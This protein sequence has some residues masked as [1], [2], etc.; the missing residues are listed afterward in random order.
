MIRS[1]LTSLASLVIAMALLSGCSGLSTRSAP[2]LD[3]PVPLTLADVAGL[4][5]V[6]IPSANRAEVKALAMGSARSKGWR[7]LQSGDDRLIVERPLDSGSPLA[8]ALGPEAANAPAGSHLEVTTYFID[9]PGALSVASRAELVMPPVLPANGDRKKAPAEAVRIDQTEVLRP[10]LDQSL[11]ALHTSWNAH[12]S[13]LARAAP[14]LPESAQGA[15]PEPRIAA[16]STPPA[17]GLMPVSAP[18]V[19]AAPAAPPAPVS[20]PAPSVNLPSL[21]M[22]SL[23]RPAPEL[24][25]AAPVLDAV[26][27]LDASPQPTNDM[28]SL[29]ATSPVIDNR[30]GAEAFAAQQGCRALPGGAVM[31]DQRTDGDIIK[32]SCDSG[33]NLLL[34]CQSGRCRSL[35]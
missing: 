4:P 31:V 22:P 9:Q 12:G 17:P 20:R 27:L 21:N 14:P 3:A 35:L 33:Q 25:T 1:P 5:I 15:A 29:P 18:A 6:S 8:R 11:S 28:L 13:R 32:V 30:A 26:P 34:H 19:A 7:I 23:H 10:S 2:E 24:R 16:G